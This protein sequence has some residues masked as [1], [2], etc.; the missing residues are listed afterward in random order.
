MTITKETKESLISEHRR[1]DDDT[2]SSE[3]QISILT[4]RINNLTQHMKANPKDYGTRR[5]LQAMVARRRK[6]LD[7]LRDSDAQRYLDIIG[8]L[9]IRK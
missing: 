1:S 2:G 8:K 3:V 6:I 4:T 9:G 7:Y 5:G